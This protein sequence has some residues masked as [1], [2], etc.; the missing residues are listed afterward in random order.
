MAQSYPVLR[1][2]GI[3]PI[4]ILIL[5]VILLQPQVSSADTTGII[6]GIITDTSGDPLPG[7]SV[8]IIGSEFGSMSDSEGEYVIAGLSPGEYTLSAR[9]VGRSTSFIEGV[10]VIA[11]QLSRIDFTLVQDITGS[12]VIRI[13]ESRRTDGSSLA[14]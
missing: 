13:I 1:R 7:A 3:L 14:A 2:N 5:S 8:M 10:T 6:A 4:L 9:M 11:G 12:T